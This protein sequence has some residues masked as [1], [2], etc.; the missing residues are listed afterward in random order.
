MKKKFKCHICGAS[1]IWLHNWAVAYGDCEGEFK[2][3]YQR[4]HSLEEIKKR[5]ANKQLK[6]L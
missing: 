5:Y 2:E 1:L 3:D 6:V 4:G